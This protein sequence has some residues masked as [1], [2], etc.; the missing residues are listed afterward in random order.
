M[1]GIVEGS[2]HISNLMVVDNKGK[3]TKIGRKLGETGK[4]V[5]YS[6]SEPR[7]SNVRAK[8]IKKNTTEVIPALKEQF[9]LISDEIT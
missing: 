2:I 8:D 7:L 3:A 1:V 4:L 5:R 6:K 9:R